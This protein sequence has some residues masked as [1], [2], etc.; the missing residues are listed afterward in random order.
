MRSDDDKPALALADVLHVVVTV[1]GGQG[2]QVE[3][4]VR[5]AAGSSWQVLASSVANAKPGED[6][7]MRWRQTLTLAPTAPGEQKVELTPLVYQDGRAGPRTAAWKPFSVT[8]ETQ[9]KDADARQARDITA[10]EDLPAPPAGPAVP[11]TLLA[12]AGVLALLTLTGAGLALR[13]R[14]GPP[15]TSPVQKALRECDRLVAMRLAEKGKGRSFVTLLTGIVRRYLERRFDLPARRRTTAELLAAVD[16][17]ED[18]PVEAKHTL[19]GFFE[20]ADRVRYA[21]QPV[22][23]GRCRELAEQVR[24]FCAATAPA[25]AGRLTAPRQP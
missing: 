14:R 12:V 3:A 23:E 20:Q 8:V 13:R 9:I 24:Q 19:R 18:V 10:T 7:R 2:L 5:P 22:D 4:P 6:G 1:E 15:P 11:W 21:G 16:A 17:R 25:K